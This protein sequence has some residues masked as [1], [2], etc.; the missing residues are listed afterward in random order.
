MHT[1]QMPQNSL[2]GT[3]LDPEEVCIA[4]FPKAFDFSIVFVRLRAVH[5]M[6]DQI[7]NFFFKLGD[8]S[9]FGSESK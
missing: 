6:L 1:G 8:F 5:E 9:N 7:T 4:I 2:F 3:A